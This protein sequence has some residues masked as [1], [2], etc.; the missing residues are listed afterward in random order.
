MALPKKKRPPL[1]P[2][3]ALEPGKY[4]AGMQEWL[5][6]TPEEPPIPGLAYQQGKIG[7]LGQGGQLVAPVPRTT[8]GPEVFGRLAVLSR[9]ANF[10]PYPVQYSPGQAAI[11]TP[12]FTE[13]AIPAAIQIG[14]KRVP[15]AQW[16]QIY[17]ELLDEQYRRL[18][19]ALQNE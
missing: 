3:L 7:V 9:L 1:R 10:Q 16:P 18:L 4:L 14:R 6:T 8:F 2:S 12:L 11:R 13:P 17:Q 15:P 19:K 5:A